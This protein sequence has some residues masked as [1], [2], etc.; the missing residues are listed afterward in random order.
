MKPYT[1]IHNHTLIH[2]F[3]RIHLP[4][5]GTTCGVGVVSPTEQTAVRTGERRSGFHTG[6]TIQAIESVLITS[7]IS[8]QMRFTPTTEFHSTNQ[9]TTE[10]GTYGSLPRRILASTR[11]YAVHGWSSLSVH[12]CPDPPNHLPSWPSLFLKETAKVYLHCAPPFPF[13]P[14]L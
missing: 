4:S 9:N 10:Q 12:S 5:P 3:C 6:C 7:S 1:L 2:L 14:L 13:L 11:Y 8:S